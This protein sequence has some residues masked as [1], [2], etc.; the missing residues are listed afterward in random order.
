MFGFIFQ[1]WGLVEML[2]M[3]FAKSIVLVVVWNIL[4]PKYF[5]FLPLK[6]QHVPFWHIFGLMVIVNILL[7]F[8]PKIATSESRIEKG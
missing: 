5:E 2:G 4:A 6:W 8:V 1:L 3:S 7:G